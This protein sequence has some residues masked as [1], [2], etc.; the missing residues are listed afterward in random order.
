[1]LLPLYTVNGGVKTNVDSG[2]GM[3]INKRNYKG[4]GKN[5]LRGSVVR[6]AA[7]ADLYLNMTWKWVR[8]HWS[9]LIN[10]A[11]LMVIYDVNQC[12]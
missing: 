5:E 9:Y 2:E 4:F 7:F 8:C 1:M 6:F 10:F 3:A 11:L 12:V